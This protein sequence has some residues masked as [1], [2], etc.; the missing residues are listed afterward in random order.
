[1]SCYDTASRRKL[2]LFSGSVDFYTFFTS[3]PRLLVFERANATEVAF[4][5]CSRRGAT[6]ERGKAVLDE[7][8]IRCFVEER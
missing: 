2:T 7:K 3:L 6:C 5:L 1:M 4:R 8:D